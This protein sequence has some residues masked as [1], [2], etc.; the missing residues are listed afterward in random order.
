MYCK[1]FWFLPEKDFREFQKI[2]R[3]AENRAFCMGTWILLDYARG[4]QNLTN[5]QNILKVLENTAPMIGNFYVIHFSYVS[6]HLQ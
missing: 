6:F 3:T 5:G 1:N 4:C 2:R